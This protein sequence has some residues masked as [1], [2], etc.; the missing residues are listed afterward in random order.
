VCQQR[1]TDCARFGQGQWPD[2][3][4]Y[5]VWVEGLCDCFNIDGPCS[6]NPRPTPS[7]TSTVTTQPGGSGGSSGAP[8]KQYDACTEYWWFYY[9]SYD[10][11]ASWQ[12]VTSWY[13]GCW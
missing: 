6:E 10:G 13:A 11:G 7:P 9:E 4:S 5:C 1:N 12:Y 2:G 3:T 8:T